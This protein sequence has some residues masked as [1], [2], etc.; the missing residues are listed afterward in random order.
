M[1]TSIQTD[2]NNEIRQYFKD[3]DKYDMLS[4]DKEIEAG[5]KIKEGDFMA[6]NELITS[7]LK[8]VVNVAKM[9]KGYGVPFSDLISEG[10]MGLIK[11]AEKYDSNKDVKFISYSVWWI[12]QYIQEFLR[13]NNIIS[14]NEYN[15]TSLYSDDL[16]ENDDKIDPNTVFAS[17]QLMS[18]D[19]D[20]GSCED[21]D[22][23][24]KGIVND[25]LSSLSKREA[26]IISKYYGLLDGKE[27]TLDEIGSIYGLTKERVRQIKEKA[28]RKLRCYVLTHPDYYKI[29]SMK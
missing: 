27:M 25:I 16:D 9:Y 8:F 2:Y 15:D 14:E 4:K 3:I 29:Q 1:K 23:V 19:F 18:D 5:H 11:A 13:K 28:L 26:D 17:E 21:K 6:R 22:N 20:I 10:N 7:N 24:R 12:R